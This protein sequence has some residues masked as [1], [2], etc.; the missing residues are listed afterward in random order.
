MAKK[1]PNRARDSARRAFS[2]AHDVSGDAVPHTDLPVHEVNASI[3]VLDLLMRSGLAPSKGEA[4]RLIEGGGRVGGETKVDDVQH[5]VGVSDVVAGH[6]LIRVGKKR[7]F[8]F[9]V[10]LKKPASTSSKNDGNSP[11]FLL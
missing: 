10:R 7:L 5:R 11:Y 1:K 3:A 6:V 8:R 4:R 2:S 9:D